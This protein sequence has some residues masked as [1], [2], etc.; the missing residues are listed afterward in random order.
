MMNTVSLLNQESLDESAQVAL[1]E[2]TST[3]QCL[4]KA[5]ALNKDFKQNF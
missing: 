4:L 1:D 5:I 3:A 2:A